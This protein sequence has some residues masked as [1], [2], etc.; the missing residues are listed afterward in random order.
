MMEVSFLKLSPKLMAALSDYWQRR[1]GRPAPARVDAGKLL[2]KPPITAIRNP[3]NIFGIVHN[4][5]NELIRLGAS[6]STLDTYSRYGFAPT[7]YYFT[8]FNGNA[9]SPESLKELVEEVRSCYERHEI[10]KEAYQ[11]M[12]RVAAYIE[13]YHTRGCL[14]RRDF[15]RN[16][17]ILHSVSK[18]HAELVSIF[19][20][21]IS[22]YRSWAPNTIASCCSSIRGFLTCLE[23]KGITGTDGIT[24][25]AI[26]DCVTQYANG[27]GYGIKL[28][29]NHLRIF[30]RLL[31]D[32]G[33]LSDDFSE[34]VPQTTPRRTV[35]RH[36]FSHDEI[37]KLLASVDRGTA[38]GKRD[39]AIMLVAVKT[40]L[41][42]VDIA[43]LT[44]PNID[45]RT[46]EIKI[47]QRKTGNALNLPLM[48]EVGNAI[49]D[50]ILNARPECSADHVFLA[51]AKTPRRIQRTT[52]SMM[53]HKYTRLAGICD[54][55]TLRRG[56]HSFRRSYAI[57][58]LESEVPIDMLSEMLGDVDI[59]SVKPYLAI[60]GN[61]LRDCA[62][63]LISPES[64]EVHDDDA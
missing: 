2:V 45:W 3:D 26:S 20:E 19:A 17:D 10:G 28:S 57:N 40:G 56:F 44:F 12:R 48:P 53:A 6:E 14:E 11:A 32:E 42:S 31:F 30:L 34:A 35:V 22:E 24:R 41:R 21:R 7:L 63:D 64:R 5:R 15:K 33:I 4:V 60:D 16:G 51:S 50:Y 38:T 27:R 49:A 61:R 25:L 43:D 36:G 9:Y 47:I 8:Q 58:L 59:N 29:L 18:E 62:I 13:A 1:F 55:S 54:E 39:Y 52:I 23:Q 46:N 37:D